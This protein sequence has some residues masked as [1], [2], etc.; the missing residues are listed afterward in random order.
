MNLT[1]PE[2][3]VINSLQIQA[4][5]AENR[6][7]HGETDA[8]STTIQGNDIITLYK[9]ITRLNRSTKITND[10]L[11]LLLDQSEEH[12]LML[13][14]FEKGC[15]AGGDGEAIDEYNGHINFVE[16]IREKIK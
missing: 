6:G 10:E 16:L 3:C 1:D 2:K 14:A 11:E 15:F 9:L 7:I 12:A 8:H 13:I 5:M 4:G